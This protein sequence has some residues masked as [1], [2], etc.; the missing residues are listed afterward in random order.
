MCLRCCVVNSR[1]PNPCCSDRHVPFSRLAA[2]QC[3]WW[4]ARWRAISDRSV[5]Q[6]DARVWCACAPRSPRKFITF[7]CFTCAHNGRT[8][9]S[10]GV[11]CRVAP[12]MPSSRGVMLWVPVLLL[13]QMAL[14]CVPSRICSICS[15][16]FHFFSSPFSAT[17]PL[18]SVQGQHV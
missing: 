16:H 4:C 6:C 8:A 14:L 18:G 17:A 2:T 3:P 5:E 1:V 12:P 9:R 11:M 15:V 10:H 7:D 13:S